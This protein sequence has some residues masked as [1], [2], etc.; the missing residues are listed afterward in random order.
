MR[1]RLVAW[2]DD[3]GADLRKTVALL[4]E[5]SRRHPHIK[6]DMTHDR[7][8]N[9]HGLLARW[10]G[11]LSQFAPD[12]TI[13]P[14]RWIGE[15]APHLYTF[16]PAFAQHLQPFYPSV[17]GPAIIDGRTHGVPWRMDAEV[18]YYRPDLLA[19][20]GH[21]PP[22]TWDELS[23]VAVEMADPQLGIYGLGM[24]GALGGGGARML[25]MLLWS[26]GGSIHDADGTVNVVT[27]EMIAAL[28]YWTRLARA[29]AL[30]PEVLS[31][32]EAGLQQAFAD[33]KLAMI[34]SDSA[35]A[36]RLHQARDR[37]DYA[38]CPLPAGDNPIALVSISYLVVMRTS[39]NRD[40]CVEF[41]KFMASSDAQQRM[42]QTGT[43]P[44][45]WQVAERFGKEPPMSAFVANLEHARSRP[46]PHWD[47]LEA[48]LAD[49]LFL[50]ISG[51]NSPTEALETVQHKYV[52]VQTAPPPQ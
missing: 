26:A 27:E 28:D 1:L 7:W 48:M 12:M 22:R 34:M 10:C 3:D 51:R 2:Q 36:T 47:L 8:A 9:A 5:F 40:A 30:Q 14:D 44:S 49:A 33:G 25:L 4:D 15:F 31:W 23:A 11:S 52:N 35:L 16:G 18:L 20:G 43:I 24:P 21:N 29:G 19:A 41:L 37:L 46:G 42:L 50:A 45:H 6:I 17:L 13:I 39:R 38:V 32:D